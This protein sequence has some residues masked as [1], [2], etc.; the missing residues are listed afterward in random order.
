MT[1]FGS[2]PV[3]ITGIGVVSVAGIGV[4]EFWAGLHRE[5]APDVV[6]RVENFD[7]GCWVG[8]REGRHLDR[9]TQFALA[10][11]LLAVADAGLDPGSCGGEAAG[12]SLGT[13]IGGVSSLEEQ[14]LVRERRGADRVSP[15]TVPMCMPNA[16]AAAISLRLGLLGPSETI[17][18]ACAAGT[19]AVAAGARL[20]GSGECDLVLAGGS[21]SSLTPTTI[22]AFTNMTAL[23]RSGLSRPFDAQRDGFAAAEGAALLVLEPLAAA[24]AR[25]GRCYAVLAAAA[26]TSDAHHITAPAPGGVGAARCMRRALH[27]AGMSPGQVAH[28][29]AHGTSTPYNDLAEATAL[30]AVFPAGVPPV[31]SVKGVLGHSLG[32]AG[33]LEAAAAAL[34]L[35]RGWVPPTTG[36]REVDPELDLDVVTTPRA[37]GAGA[38]LSNSFGFGG[39]NGCLL[40]TPAPGCG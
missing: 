23:T 19:H 4:E 10:A 28:V 14:I 37:L 36:V 29:N 6:R 17:T 34:T 18:T 33:A 26:S 15:Y 7:P 22:G 12:V 25:G 40:L 27:A 39:H 9:F 31:T 13:G 11:A 21:E 1:G 24:L 8:R 3:A 2:R 5:P 38:V 35:H 30:H 20:V 32:A 16:G